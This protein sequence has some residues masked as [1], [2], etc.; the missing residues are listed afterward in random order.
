[1]IKGKPQG[2]LRPLIGMELRVLFF[3]EQ[4]ANVYTQAVNARENPFLETPFSE[5][6]IR[7]DRTFMRKEHII[8]YLSLKTSKTFV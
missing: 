8:Q 7:P 6:D 1:M 5:L 2:A 3:L 4:P